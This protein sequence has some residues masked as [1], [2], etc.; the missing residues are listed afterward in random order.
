MTTPAA[1]PP[2]ANLCGIMYTVQVRE[3]MVTFRLSDKYGPC[4]T[5]ICF[6][7]K[8]GCWYMEYSSDDNTV[9]V[10]HIA[11]AQELLNEWYG[12]NHFGKN[13]ENNP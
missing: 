3:G 13:G 5:V 7:R 8:A 12:P 9:M 10:S 4:Y 2:Q 11:A 1:V 6:S